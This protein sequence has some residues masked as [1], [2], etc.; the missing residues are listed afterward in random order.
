MSVEKLKPN[1]ADVARRAGVSRTTVSFVLNGRK[2]VS[3]PATTRQHVLDVAREMG[4]QPNIAARALVTG[5]TQVV[6]VWMV[7]MHRPHFARALHLAWQQAGEYGFEMIIG[8]V[9]RQDDRE[10]HSRLS[11]WPSPRHQ[12]GPM[13]R[14]AMVTPSG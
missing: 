6:A 12:V 9:E 10:R 7:E 14:T 4:Y 5:Q 13:S 11:R 2:D 1:S 8:N 3:I